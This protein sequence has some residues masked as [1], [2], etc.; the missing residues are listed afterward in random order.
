MDVKVIS[1]P[2]RRD[3]PS[4]VMP[5]VRQAKLR[6][7]FNFSGRFDDWGSRRGRRSYAKHSLQ[8]GTMRSVNFS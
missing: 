5:V 1:S 7:K 6:M 4:F 2:R 3:F 8:D